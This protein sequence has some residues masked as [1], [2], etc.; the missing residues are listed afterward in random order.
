MLAKKFSGPRIFDHYHF[1]SFYVKDGD[2]NKLEIC[3]MEYELIKVELKKEN[4]EVFLMNS[5]TYIP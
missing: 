4:I 2:G 3:C 5:E 1:L